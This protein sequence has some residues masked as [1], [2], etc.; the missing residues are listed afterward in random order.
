M[1]VDDERFNLSY[2][3]RHT[4]LPPPGDERQLKRLTGRIMSQQL[5][6]GKPLWELWYVEGLTNDRFAVISKMHHSM[7]DGISGVDL[8]ASMM[9]PDQNHSVATPPRWVPRPAPTAGRLAADELMRM[10]SLP[11]DVASGARALLTQPRRSAGQ[12]TRRVRRARRSA[13]GCVRAGIADADSTAT[14][15]RTGAST[16]PSST[17]TS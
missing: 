3:V 7:V 14:S 2:H 1:W 17:S 15:A 12:R 10:A 13:V 8:M 6:R 5:D 4:A 9:G 16:G 11:L